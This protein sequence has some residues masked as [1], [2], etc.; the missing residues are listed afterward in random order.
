MEV[1]ELRKYQQ[2]NDCPT[3]SGKLMIIGGG[4]EREAILKHML[5]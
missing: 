1:E 5:T 3:P 4:K 2:E